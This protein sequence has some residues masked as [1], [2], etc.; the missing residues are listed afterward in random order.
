MSVN[1]DINVLREI[2][3]RRGIEF[4]QR[5]FNNETNAT[6]ALTIVSNVGIHEIPSNLVFGEIYHASEGILDFSNSKT[7]Y[8]QYIA[9]IERLHVKLREK[10]WTDVYLIPFGHPTLS[11]LIKLAVFRVLR[12]ETKDIFFFGNGKYDLLSI[13]LRKVLAN[14]PL[15]TEKK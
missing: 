8:D 3:E 9:I 7:V 5:F 11:M 4:V 15:V 10:T 12:E 14:N 2:Y 1:Q 13:D 6:S